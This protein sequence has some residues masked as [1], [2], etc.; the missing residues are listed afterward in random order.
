[1]ARVGR[2]P[3][4]HAAPWVGKPL[5][6]QVEP[7]VGSSPEHQTQSGVSGLVNSN[8]INFFPFIAIVK[9]FAGL[10]YYSLEIEELLGDFCGKG[11]GRSCQGGGRRVGKI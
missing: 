2:R 10:A 6:R 7:G 8:Q 3:F 9:G 4:R 11:R 1:M 5:I